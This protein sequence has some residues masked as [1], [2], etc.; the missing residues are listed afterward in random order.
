MSSHERG[1]NELKDFVSESRFNGPDVVPY[2]ADPSSYSTAIVG[3]SHGF[4]DSRASE[5]RPLLGR[6]RMESCSDSEVSCNVFEDAEFTSLIR[7]AEQAI[8]QGVLP[9]RI[10]QGSSGSYFAKDKDGV[11]KMLF[12]IVSI[13]MMS[14]SILLEVGNLKHFHLAG[15]G[16]SR[17]PFPVL[18]H[19]WL[20]KTL[21]LDFVLLQEVSIF[22]PLG[23][24]S[25][26]HL[27]HCILCII[28]YLL[29]NWST[30]L[31]IKR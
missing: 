7:S 23:R 29:L 9:E 3:G 14:F 10:Y 24:N 20:G 18:T 15:G 13:Q 27:G 28:Y 2:H 22:H 25:K 12:E 8:D 21:F 4:Y 31:L 26:P 16:Q 19:T 5:Q 11:R 17:E 6:S 30:A 1:R